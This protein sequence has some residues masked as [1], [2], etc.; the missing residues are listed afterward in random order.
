MA[1]WFPDR[2]FFMR[3]QGQVRFIKV[4]SRMQKIAASVVVI[5]LL[6]WA[7]SMAVMSWTQY[8]AQADRLSL[9]EREAE[10][11]TAQERV[12]AYRDDLGSVT[13]DLQK[14]QEFL[15]AMTAA[16][17]EDIKAEDSSTAGTVT[18]SSSEA[19]E[20]VSKVSS[21]IPEA[22]ELARI[23]ARQLAFVEK[24]TRFADRRAARAERAI[25]QLGLNPT[26]ML[27]GADREAMGGPLEIL[28][29]G[30]NGSIDP[31]FERLGLSLARMAALERGLDA[32]PQITPTNLN[33]TKVSSGFGYR[34]DPFTGGGAMH[35]GLDFKGPRGAPIYAAAKGVV[36]YAG[37][38]SGYGKTIEI[39]HGNGMMT[40][41]AHMSRY[42]ATAGQ[43]VDA[44]DPI[45]AIG[46]TGRSTG[47]HLHFE[48]RIN[49]RAVNPRPFLE[50]APNVLKEARRTG[51][52]DNTRG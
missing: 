9:L 48:V 46:S 31:R 28:A 15:E 52:G 1:N 17:P 7:I 37:W 45:G 33:V 24:L 32:I 18:D 12:N 11:A 40:R 14:R 39:T 51:N 5:A 34:R 29:T 23:E 36:S 35:S 30:A 6:V 2:E 10:V 44:G 50:A 3:S 16:L 27:K 4:S 8:R 13:E 21:S 20:T 25:R 43:V 41:Y 38:K 49:E 22:A 42:S 26:A 47:P 19:A